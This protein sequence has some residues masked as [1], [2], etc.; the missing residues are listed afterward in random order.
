VGGCGAGRGGRAAKESEA[1]RSRPLADGRGRAVR[2]DGRARRRRR[3]RIARSGGGGGG[4]GGG[5]GED[6]GGPVLP[7]GCEA[8]VGAVRAGFRPAAG[9]RRLRACQAAAAGLRQGPGRDEVA[10][11]GNGGG[12][13]VGNWA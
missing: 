4:G 3:I 5:A 2:R 10:L 13:A 6:R 9:R 1:R 7:A 8:A 12:M 11:R